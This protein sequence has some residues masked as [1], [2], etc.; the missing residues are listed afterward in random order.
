MLATKNYNVKEYA[1][2]LQLKVNA[3][4]EK[5][6]QISR[7]QVLLKLNLAP[8]QAEKLGL[9]LPKLLTKSEQAKKRYKQN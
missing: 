3:I 1:N 8:Y 7:R 4:V 2:Q 9:V 5:D 6:P